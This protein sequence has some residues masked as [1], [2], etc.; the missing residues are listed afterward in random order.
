[1][2]NS[3]LKYMRWTHVF[4]VYIDIILNVLSQLLKGFYLFQHMRF[5]QMLS[6][7]KSTTQLA[8]A[9]SLMAEDREGAAVLLSSLLT[10]IL[11]TYLKTLIFLA[12][13]KTL[14]PRNILKITSRHA[15]MAPI[16]SGIISRS[17]LLAV[18]CLMICLKIWRKCFLLVALR[19]PIDT[20][21]RLKIDFMDPVSTAGL[22]LSEEEI[23]LL[24]TLTVRDSSWFCFHY[25]HLVYSFSLCLMKQQFSLNRSDKCMI[26]LTLSHWL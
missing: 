23:W 5:S 13:T 15:R 19:P 3:S 18:D 17:F 14:G 24:P 26:S 1:M 11:M 4:E 25:A 20:Q 12:R 7:G 9:L 22:S 21:Y 16:D 10:S 8:T 2:W 6:G